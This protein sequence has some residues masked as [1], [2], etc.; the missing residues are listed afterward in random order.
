MGFVQAC[1]YGGEGNFDVAHMFLLLGGAAAPLD[2][3]C[4]S[5]HTL[6]SDQLMW[7]GHRRSSQ[8][9]TSDQEK[10]FWWTFPGQYGGGQYYIL[11]FPPKYL[12]SD[13]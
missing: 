5:S 13:E 11:D 6:C 10:S 3:W 2:R 12:F 8:V 1:K 7:K 4:N 9:I